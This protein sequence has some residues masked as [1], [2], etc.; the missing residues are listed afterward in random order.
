MCSVCIRY[1]CP[2]GCPNYDEKS[3]EYGNCLGHCQACRIALY[4][5]DLAVY[6][7]GK[8]YCYA[9]ADLLDLPLYSLPIFTYPYHKTEGGAT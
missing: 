1:N 8:P 5:G 4:D 7:L 9:C 3:A 2:A 6:Y